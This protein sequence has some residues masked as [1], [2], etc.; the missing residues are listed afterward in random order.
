[1][2][3]I[4]VFTGTR[5]EYGLLRWVMETIQKDVA[6][7]LQIIA[8]GSHFSAMHGWT[9]KEIE[10]DGFKINRKV[11]M[12]L[13]SDTSLAVNK[14][15]ALAQMGIAQALTDLNPDILLVLGDRYEALAA[16]LAATIQRVPVGHIHGGEITEG[17]L[18]DSFRHAITKLSSLHFVAAEEYR[19]TVIQMG[20]QPENVHTVGGLGVEA[21][22]RCY[23]I[24]KKDL[25]DRLQIEWKNRSMLVT[26]HPVTVEGADESSRQMKE[27]LDALGTFPDFTIIITRPNADQGYDALN[28]AID[29]FVASNSNAYVFASMGSQK[30][31]SCMALVDVIVGNSS[32]ALLEGPA[33][34][35]PAVNIGERQKSRRKA[36]N[37]IDC[38]PEAAAIRDSILLATGKAFIQSLEGMVNPFGNGNS[39]ALIVEKIRS[40][41]FSGLSPKLF[42][43]IVFDS[44]V[45]S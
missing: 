3:K 2:K 6:L 37:V 22:L 26:F 42:N 7:E 24:N 38:K 18:D 32:S 23:L 16:T 33:F 25:S 34:Q 14:S 39:S 43:R 36:K 31:L 20:E 21:A 27:L 11:E 9:Y 30:Y 44:G 8:S 45:V 17:A 41:D 19:S 35:K 15:M 12:L 4:C 10:N 29:A 40:L 1:M 5:A 13:A 28:K